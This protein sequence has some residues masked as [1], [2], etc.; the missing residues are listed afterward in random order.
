[1]WYLRSPRCLTTSF[2]VAAISIRV[3][4]GSSSTLA[5]GLQSEAC[6]RDEARATLLLS[7]GKLHYLEV[8]APD[9]AQA[10]LAAAAPSLLHTL[11]HMD[12]PGIVTWAAHTNNIQGLAAKLHKAGVAF[13]GPNPGS[14]KRP[15]GQML[16]WQTLNLDD[17]REGLLPFFIH[18]G[19]GAVHP[20]ADAPSGC[21]LQSFGAASPD[22]HELSGVFQQLGIEV[23]V[24][25]GV[26]PA[27]HAQIAGPRGELTLSS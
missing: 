24:E 23:Q 22:P 6:I 19:A 9:P 26:K 4:L 20:S 7:L 12:A 25:Q 10:S 21:R 2:S 5:C 1:M 16:H 18:W 11:R 15:N 3:L 8:I 27:L 17:N 14:R 13:E